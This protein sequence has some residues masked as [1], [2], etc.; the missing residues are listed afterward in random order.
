MAHANQ[1]NAKIQLLQ[2]ELDSI[3]RQGVGFAAKRTSLENEI[4]Q[5]T[6][7]NSSQYKET[8]LDQFKTLTQVWKSFFA[9]QKKYT[10]LN[11]LEESIVQGNQMMKLAQKE[12]RKAAGFSNKERSIESNLKAQQLQQEALQLLAFL[13]P[14]EPAPRVEIPVAEAPAVLVREK[15]VIEPEPPVP[16]NLHHLAEAE[17]IEKPTEQLSLSTYYTIQIC[18]ARQPE[19]E[20]NLKAKY[21]GAL[22]WIT[23]ESEGWFRY[24]VGKFSNLAEAK[25]AMQTE[26]IGTFV[27]AYRNNSRISVAEAQKLLGQ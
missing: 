19:A 21:S 9:G 25:K 3:N 13:T 1:T 6:L 12:Y 15:P 26:A 27:T 7:S 24:S 14:E 11:R 22:P 4:Y 20:P 5:R 17:V 8:Y 16:T 18:A 2:M 23:N 10:E